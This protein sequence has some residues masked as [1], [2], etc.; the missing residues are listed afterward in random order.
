VEVPEVEVPE[1]EVMDFGGTGSPAACEGDTSEPNE[2]EATSWL[3][4]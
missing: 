3:N 4:T 1:V 2:E